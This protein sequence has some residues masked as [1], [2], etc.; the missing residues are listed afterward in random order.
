M[1]KFRH[2]FTA[3]ITV[4]TLIAPVHAAPKEF[5]SIC[6]SDPS[7]PKAF[8]EWQ[9]QALKKENCARP[10]RYVKKKL[11]KKSPKTIG[12]TSI[13]DLPQSQCKLPQVGNYNRRGFGMGQGNLHANAVIQVVPIK[14]SDAKSESNPQKDYS[15]FFKFIHDAFANISDTGWNINIRI[16][17]SYIEVPVELKSYGLGFNSEHGRSADRTRFVRDILP[18]IQSKVSIT[19]AGIIWFVVPPK[20]SSKLFTDTADRFDINVGNKNYAMMAFNTGIDHYNESSWNARYFIGTVHELFHLGLSM[21]DHY[22]DKMGGGGNFGTGQWGNMS[23]IYMDWLAWDKWVA[24]LIADNQIICVSGNGNNYWIKPSTIQG[25]YEKLL[26]IPLGGTKAIAVE[27]IRNSGFNYKIPKKHLGAL[28]YTVDT[29]VQD[30]GRGVEVI[31]P[32]K[33]KVRKYKS[34]SATND[35][36]RYSDYALKLNES[37]TISGYKITVVESGDFGDVIN[38]SKI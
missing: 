29:S 11:P 22:G 30:H 2:F 10:I 5:N 21:D 8:V 37:L 13:G 14:T 12:V 31:K 38:V 15:Q 27:S 7:V 36:F 32:D 20:T 19:D 1:L 35:D 25:A 28:V 26:M 9:K 16:P 6:Q 4:C 33:R 17:D 18:T 23:E 24:G 34:P 3:F